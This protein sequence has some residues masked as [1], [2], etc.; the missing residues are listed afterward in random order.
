MVL[1]MCEMTIIQVR[2]TTIITTLEMLVIMAL[3]RIKTVFQT[4]R[5]IVQL[6]LMQTNL[7]L[8]MMVLVMCV[9]MMQIMME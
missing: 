6:F 9:I 1:E 7:T 5:T 3:T 4:L 8:T 2:R